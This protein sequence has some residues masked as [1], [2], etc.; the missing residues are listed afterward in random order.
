MCASWG[1]L[2]IWGSVSAVI[3]TV[4]M[5]FVFSVLWALL[6]ASEFGPMDQRYREKGGGC[7]LFLVVTCLVFLGIS[8]LQNSP[9]V[10]IGGCHDP[11]SNAIMGW[12]M[13]GVAVVVAGLGPLG[14][15]FNRRN[16]S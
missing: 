5:S 13:I 8:L 3:L 14:A 2:V 4:V 15:F 16:Q 12:A 6:N 10:T 7:V 1:Q 9:I 11:A